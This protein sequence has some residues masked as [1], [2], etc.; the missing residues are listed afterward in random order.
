M[1]LN[2]LHAQQ[3]KTL[4]SRVFWVETVF[5]AGVT[6]MM[7]ALTNVISELRS[8]AP[9]TMAG[10]L[11]DMLQQTGTSSMGHM[12]VVVLAAALM[13]HE[14]SRRSLH[15]W[16]SRGVSRS[17][18]LWAKFASFLVPIAL[19]L[20]VTAVVTVPIAAAFTLAE[21]GTVGPLT[22][23][24][25][26]L[27]QT[28]ALGAYAL[29]PYAALAL[30]LAVVGRSMLFAVGGSLVLTLLAE[31]ILWQ[32]LG[33]IGGGAEDALAYL[34]WGLASGLM[35][36]EMGGLSLLTPGA[37]AAVIAVYIVAL[38]AAATLLFQ[39]QDLSA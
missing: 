19:F 31:T 11:R 36:L 35:G 13:A 4:R 24:L 8:D 2:V 32:I 22:G 39:R 12:L 25:V 27:A 15:L 5:L 33:L 23:E 6:A 14:Y 16:L 26:G 7:V 3:T 9:V 1:F 18:F 20:L 34:P 29:V 37:A 38:L 10:Q 30:L 17:A 21:H 28:A